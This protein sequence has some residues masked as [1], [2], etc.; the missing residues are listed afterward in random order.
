MSIIKRKEKSIP[1]NSYYLPLRH[2]KIHLD[3][4]IFT[5]Q[6]VIWLEESNKTKRIQILTTTSF[7]R[8]FILVAIVHW[9]I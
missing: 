5:K 8:A 3:T 1:S 2:T 7:A 4:Y 6:Q 9:K